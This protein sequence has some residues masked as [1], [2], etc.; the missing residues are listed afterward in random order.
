MEKSFL[1]DFKYPS[2]HSLCERTMSEKQ[3]VITELYEYTVKDLMEPRKAKLFFVEKTAGIEQVFSVLCRKNHVWVVDSTETLRV[4]G[5]ITESDTL[6]LFSPPYT[7]LQFF[8]APH[9]QSFQYGLSVA[10]EEIMSQQ[11]IT[12][13][14]DEK[15]IDV[16]LKMKQHKIKQLAVVDENER[17]VG[18]ITL[19]HLIEEYNKKQKKIIQ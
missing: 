9:L 16:I 19:Q 6:V 18:E 14:P 4:V 17:L 13:A 11:P 15:I 8:D 5:V 12:A 10:A 7:P 3:K 1:G 2:F